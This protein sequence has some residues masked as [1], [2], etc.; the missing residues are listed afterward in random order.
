MRRLWYYYIYLL[1]V[2]SFFRY[3]IRLPEVI[4]ELWFKPLLWLVPLFWW[5]LS[6][7]ER[8]SMFGGK[9]M[10][11][12]GYGIVLGLVY[13]VLITRFNLL[14]DWLNVN[15]V[16]VAVATAITEELAFSGFVAGYLEKIKK[17][18]WTNLLMVGLMVAVIR[19]P[20]LIFV[21]KLGV[22]NL[23]GVFLFAGASGVINAWIRV[24]TGNVTGSI[25]ARAMMNLAVLA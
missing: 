3:F 7:K 21:Y 6:L 16:G 14:V 22:V 11:S 19:L 10:M 2:W 1:I 5:G 20:I 4:E 18:N 15:L 17:G 13:V 24:E 8:I 12:I 9:L 25:V 23:A